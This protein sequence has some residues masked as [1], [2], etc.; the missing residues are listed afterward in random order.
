MASLAFVQE[1]E[2]AVAPWKQSGKRLARACGLVFRRFVGPY[3]LVKPLFQ[4]KRRLIKERNSL[5]LADEDEY[6]AWLDIEERQLPMVQ[7]ALDRLQYNQARRHLDIGASYDLCSLVEACRVS[8]S[9]AS[10]ASTGSP[11]IPFP[12]RRP[13]MYLL[14]FHS[15]FY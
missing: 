4:E 9:P 10:H 5:D 2:A 14:I 13:E 12:K 8:G 15:I 1:I 11:A 3:S 6:E 7:A